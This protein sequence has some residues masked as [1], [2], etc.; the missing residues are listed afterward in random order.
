MTKSTF[1]PYIDFAAGGAK[2]KKNV[3]NKVDGKKVS[4]REGASQVLQPTSQNPI[5]NSPFLCHWPKRIKK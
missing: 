1:S 3:L 5:F 4:D 2:R